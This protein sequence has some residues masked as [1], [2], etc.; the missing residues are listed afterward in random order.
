LVKQDFLKINK[1]I[2]LI[3]EIHFRIDIDYKTAPEI[4]GAVLDDKKALLL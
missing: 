4:S 1:N 3:L 2:I